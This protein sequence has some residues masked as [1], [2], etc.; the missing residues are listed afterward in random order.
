MGVVCIVGHFG[1]LESMAVNAESGYYS[2][3]PG[4]DKKR[5]A[6]KVEDFGKIKY[7]KSI[8]PMRSRNGLMTLSYGRIGIR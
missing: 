4:P 8:D 6:V 1:V 2:S 3:L 7:F 5:Y